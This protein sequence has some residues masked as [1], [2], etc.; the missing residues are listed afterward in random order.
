MKSAHDIVTTLVAV[1]VL[2]IV[3]PVFLV[4]WLSK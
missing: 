1:Y 4:G 3:L 2:V